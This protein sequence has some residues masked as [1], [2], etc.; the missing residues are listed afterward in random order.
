ML[1]SSFHEVD[2]AISDPTT[3]AQNGWEPHFARLRREDPVHYVADSIH[4]SYWAVTKFRDIEEVERNH[5]IFSSDAELGGIQIRDR[6]PELVVR[7]FFLMD[8]PQ[9]SERRAV[10]NVLGL[11]RGVDPLEPLIRK[12]TRQ[13][14]DSL[15]RGE[16]FD[17]VDRVSVEI[18]STM[19]AAL[20]DYPM[21]K[22]RELVNW[23]DVITADLSDPHSPVKSEDEREAAKWRFSDR[24]MELWQDRMQRPAEN[25]LIS[26][27]AHS[28]LF[29]EIDPREKMGTLTT[30]LVGG[31]DTTRN[32]MSGGL[33]AL[34]SFPDQ[35]RRLRSDQSLI[36]TF[37]EESLRWQTPV[38]H[39]RRTALE[40]YDLGGKHI[41]KGDKVVLWYISANRDE[42]V[43]ERPDEFTLDRKR[44]ETH[45]SF[46]HG[47]HR[48]LGARLARLQLNVLWEEFLARDIEFEVVQPPEYSHHL[49]IRGIRSMQVQLQA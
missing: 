11:P 10:V 33:Y 7:S 39:F 4:G 3:Y 30:F 20:M 26:I 9:H 46:G 23:S 28:P 49:S 42:D 38:I 37:V 44:P 43:I 1:S 18:T 5:R 24:M 32:T 25:N 36:P 8:P 27:L 45:L 48:C 17:W 31:N 14:L 15:P 47:I 41:A 16:A 21:E 2:T 34:S 6:P 40:D 12:T 22:K 29:N 13:V 19:L 35:L